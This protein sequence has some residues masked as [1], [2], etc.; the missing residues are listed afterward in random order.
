MT[1]DPVSRR[2]SSA[3]SR[4]VDSLRAQSASFAPSRARPSAAALPNPWLEAA[5]MATRSLRPRSIG[6]PSPQ[7]IVVFDQPIVTDGTEDVEVERVFERHR[8]MRH[9]GGDA[10]HLALRDHHLAAFQFK[11]QRAF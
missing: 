8:A 11:F 3:V 10:Q 5:R 4:S 6:F 9:I 7:I 2:I 1:S